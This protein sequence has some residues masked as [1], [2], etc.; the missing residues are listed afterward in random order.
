MEKR[1]HIPKSVGWQAGAA[2][3]AAE[4]SRLQRTILAGLARA[5][6][7]SDAGA[8][9]FAHADTRR[10]GPGLFTL[11][12][13]N[14]SDEGSGLVSQPRHAASATTPAPPPVSAQGG[15]A[16]SR[17]KIVQYLEETFGT[18]LP[19]GQTHYGVQTPAGILIGTGAADGQVQLGRLF[20]RGIRQDV[21]G[22]WRQTGT[23]TA[24]APG[25]YVFRVVGEAEPGAPHPRFAV[26][27]DHR[28]RQ[29]GKRIWTR[30]ELGFQ[31]VFDVTSE[32][33]QGGAGAGAARGGGILPDGMG[34]TLVP[35]QCRPV[36]DTRALSGPDSES[37][38]DDELW[39]LFL[40][41]CNARA[42]DNLDLSERF[43]RS[44]L[45]PRYTGPNGAVNMLSDLSISNL[46]YFQENLQLLRGLLT[47]YHKL[48][49][50]I[51]AVQTEL[52]ALLFSDSKGER[53]MLSPLGFGAQ[54]IAPDA[55]WP[56]ARRPGRD[57]AARADELLRV[58]REKSEAFGTTVA[59]IS[60]L[61][62]EEPL[63]SF[64]INGLTA[65][66]PDPE[67]PHFRPIHSELADEE[68]IYR[69]Q[70]Q[71]LVV[72]DD[73]LRKIDLARHL[74]CR[75]P[76]RVLDV[77]LVYEKV[78]ADLEGINPRFDE[79]A[80]RRIAEHK[81]LEQWTDIGLGAA[82]LVL[83]VGGLVVSIAGGPAG[84]IVFI[85]AVGV[86][87]GGVQALR[88]FDKATALSAF[89][90][91]SPVRG[92]GLA[93]LEAAE[94]AQFWAAVDAVMAGVDLTLAART[95]AQLRRAR[96][97][98][99]APGEAEELARSMQA[100]ERLDFAGLLDRVTVRHQ[101]TFEP[102]EVARINSLLT[103]GGRQK[104]QA[105]ELAEEIF[106][107]AILSREDYL[108]LTAKF[109]NPIRNS[110]DVGVDLMFVRRRLLEEV[111]GEVTS[112][113]EARRLVAA[114]TDEQLTRL[115][116][117]VMRGGA[118][119]NL[120]AIEVKLSSNPR[121]TE[122]LLSTAAEGERIQQ[123]RDWYVGLIR[124]MKQPANAEVHATARLLEKIIGPDA[125]YLERLTRIGIT[126][127]PQGRLLLTRLTDE[128]IEAGQ[129]IKALDNGPVRIYKL[130]LNKNA[131]EVA[132]LLART[133]QTPEIMRTLAHKHTQAQS[134]RGGLADA[135]RA[136]ADIRRSIEHAE[137]AREAARLAW[138]N[139]R[140]GVGA[141][142]DL[143]QATGLPAGIARTQ[144]LH[145]ANSLAR[146]YLEAASFKV[147]EAENES[148]KADAARADAAQQ[149]RQ[150][151]AATEKLLRE[152]PEL[153]EP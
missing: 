145:T 95:V 112:P 33:W 66:E 74:L 59:A 46:G 79:V 85:E 11:A 56:R 32:T 53:G 93:S 72:L 83:F 10:R 94:A 141:L 49:A 4:R 81:S 142:N 89:A 90:G 1:F 134:Y 41:L 26:V 30:H 16:M 131:D 84:V 60:R 5:V 111:F 18:A 34:G 125:A 51:E 77:P 40:N 86:G 122:E 151:E 108:P 42:I 9:A 64:F 121:P 71:I 105:G 52:D 136:I 3:D 20:L 69:V 88:S 91:T 109:R 47:A 132:D 62:H 22:D 67:H 14:P 12:S 118:P 36:W 54:K 76:E 92:G 101:L 120:V 96:V 50:Q 98:A 15:A 63:L 43:V 103:A 138:E 144:A 149:G 128:I 73:I 110:P 23:E 80:Q 6:E 140:R 24:F 13:Y 58:Y 8:A 152:S 113:D 2:E 153:F 28:G 127:D 147:E 21:Q 104:G 100:A 97:L 117:A 133:P 124:R 68:S 146:T 65:G 70:Q 17:E 114:A 75:V 106:Q 148:R 7:G 19:V 130:A 139:W 82:G 137:R 25:R 143:D 126:V 135:Q 37:L 87:L 31:V 119:D 129:Q 107:R 115:G 44:E 45:L 39:R 35:L 55:G 116:N 57:E 61:I 99:N 38:S 123:H 48:S 29:V 150:I 78:R 102:S 27:T